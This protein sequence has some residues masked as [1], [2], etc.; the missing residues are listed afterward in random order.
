M[1]IIGV[2]R[3]SLMIKVPSRVGLNA[4]MF[5]AAVLTH[6]RA[7]DAIPLVAYATFLDLFMIITSASLV[8]ETG[9]LILKFTRGPGSGKNGAG[10]QM[11]DPDNTGS[12]DHTF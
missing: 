1:L 3:Y 11:V 7:T 4:S 5:L 10:Q 6:W 9:T 8:P 2:A 12:F